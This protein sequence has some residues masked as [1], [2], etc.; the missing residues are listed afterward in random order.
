[1]FHITKK[2]TTKKSSRDQAMSSTVTDAAHISVGDR[3]GL[4]ACW[5]ILSLPSSS[6]ALVF[7]ICTVTICIVLFLFSPEVM[8][9]T[10]HK[11]NLKCCQTTQ[12]P[13]AFLFCVSPS[14]D[15]LGTL[16]SEEFMVVLL[17][18]SNGK[19]LNV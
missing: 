13:Q 4:Q 11:T 18:M 19:V 15:D 17:L 9:P 12:H 1:M 16:K 7:E 14:H 5:F 8:A 10:L 2:K 3:S 6:Q